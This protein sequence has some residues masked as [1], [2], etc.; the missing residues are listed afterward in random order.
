MAKGS[1]NRTKDRESYRACPLWDNLKRKKKKAVPSFMK[2]CE[3]AEPKLTPYSNIHWCMNCG[4][5]IKE[6]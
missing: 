3:C 4:K 2:K 1:R 5:E 6:V